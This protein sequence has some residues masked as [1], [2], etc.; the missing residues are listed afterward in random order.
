MYEQRTYR[1]KIKGSGLVSFTAKIKETDLFI[2]ARSE[3][4]TETLALIENYRR[5]LEEYVR[6]HPLF[7]H[8]LEPLPVEA[9]APGIVLLMSQAGKAAG[10]GPMAAV[11]GAMAELVGKKL[12]DFSPEV[13]VEN[14]GD[15][16]MKISK[17]RRI[18]IFAGNSPFT[19]KLALEI[20]PEETPLGIC[21]S[22]GTVGPSLSLGSTDATIV[23]SVSTALADAAATAVGNL[24]K[25]ADDV[26]GALDYGKGIKGVRGIVIIVGDK[27]GAWGE[28]KLVKI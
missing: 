23:T 26:Q 4:K 9:D 20:D 10:V 14:G 24:V 15:I 11:A 1:H 5:P 22:S 3:L 17:R 6:S 21:T 13:I 8:S 18:G 19:D 25:T 7:L 2:L 27:M 16:F 28:I 12:L